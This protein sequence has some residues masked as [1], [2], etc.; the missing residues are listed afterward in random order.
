VP[1]YHRLWF[2][3]DQEKLV[4]VLGITN[5]SE[6]LRRKMEEDAKAAETMAAQK[7]EL[8]RLRSEVRKR[9][10]AFEARAVA[11]DEALKLFEAGVLH[12]RHALAADPRASMSFVLLRWLTNH[13]TGKKLADVLPAEYRREELVQVMARWPES[14]PELVKLLDRRDG[15]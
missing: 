6:Y 11:Q 3:E 14:R 13:P 15:P 4:Q 9:E 10:A 7:V 8:D 12:V 1:P 5:R 2:S